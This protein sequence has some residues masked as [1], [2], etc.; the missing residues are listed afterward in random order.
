MLTRSYCPGVGILR[1]PELP[2]H[3]PI[4][5]VVQTTL[6]P[7]DLR[8]GCSSFRPASTSFFSFPASCLCVLTTVGFLE[9]ACED[10]TL[11]GRRV[12]ETQFSSFHFSK[13]VS[14]FSS[15]SALEFRK[16]VHCNY[17]REV[18]LIPQGGKRSSQPQSPGP[19]VAMQL[20]QETE[21]DHDSYSLKSTFCKSPS[22]WSDTGHAGSFCV[23]LTQTKV[24]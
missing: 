4:K 22:F 13:C 21:M 19:A 8:S 18:K 20:A 2:G 6:E 1:F 5:R 16:E 12:Q 23:N 15:R 9:T 10:T 11:S 24:I 3:S 7:R 17:G 14:T